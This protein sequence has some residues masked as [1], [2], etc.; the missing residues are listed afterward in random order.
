MVAEHGP[1]PNVIRT[2]LAVCDLNSDMQP[3]SCYR[4]RMNYWITFFVMNAFIYI[5]PVYCAARAISDLRAGMPLLSMAGGI[6]AATLVFPLAAAH[7]LPDSEALAWS[8]L[9]VVVLGNIG[10]AIYVIARTVRDALERNIKWALAGG[11][12]VVLLS[13]PWAWT[14]LMPS[15][16]ITIG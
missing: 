10:V 14:F 3:C 5:V 8:L 1:A 7:F 13:L 15:N 11:L 12:C 9:G 4:K 6:C 2:R 16:E